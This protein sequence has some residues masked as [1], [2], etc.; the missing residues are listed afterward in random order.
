VDDIARGT[1]FAEDEVQRPENA[2]LVAAGHL[3]PFGLF[4]QGLKFSTYL[5]KFYKLKVFKT[6]SINYKMIK[7]S[8]N[9]FLS[10]V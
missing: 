5:V 8:L 4:S 10:L 9:I 6:H 1:V 7:I 3:E 2:L